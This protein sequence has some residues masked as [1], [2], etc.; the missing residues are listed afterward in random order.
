MI[1]ERED[2]EGVSARI[3]TGWDEDSFCLVAVLREEPNKGP[4]RRSSCPLSAC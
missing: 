2:A 3:Y 4:I 1:F